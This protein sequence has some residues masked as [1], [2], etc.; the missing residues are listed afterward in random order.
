VAGARLT[1]P[2]LTVGAHP[3]GRSLERQ[4][5]PYADRLT[6]HVIPDCG[7]IIPL[8]RPAALLALL[9]PFLAADDGRG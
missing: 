6:G 2:V 4:L 5:R 3:V 7:H 1:V 8:H 9:E